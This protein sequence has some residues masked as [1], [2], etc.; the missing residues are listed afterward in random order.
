MSWFRIDDGVAFHRKVI[1]AGNEAFG[2]WTRMGAHSSSQLTDGLIDAGTALLIAGRRSVIEKLVGAELLEVSGDSYQIHD[3]L[4]YN[5]SA[6]E[7]LATRDSRAQTGRKGGLRSAEQRA[8]QPASSDSTKPEPK[9]KQVASTLLE[10][11]L[12]V[13]SDTAEA[14]PNPVP[15]RPVPVPSPEKTSDQSLSSEARRV[16]DH[17]RVV[18]KS[19]RSVL[20][21]KRQ[22]LVTARIKSHGVAACILAVNGCR[23]HAWSMGQNPENEK[24]NGFDLIFR[25]AAH[26]EKFIANAPREPEKQAPLVPLSPEQ[27]A[28]MRNL[29]ARVAGNLPIETPAAMGT[30]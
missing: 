18:M 20:D 4:E 9:S 10:A 11:G 15:S 3:F 27:A 1:K 24:H 30:P 23:A 21:E 12:P 5:P 13:G 14:K 16:F 8:K 2:A 17:W 29:T 28:H 26:V 7:V 6:A 22:R 19:P 25:D